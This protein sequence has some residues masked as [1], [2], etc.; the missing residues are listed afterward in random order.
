MSRQ[1][2]SRIL[3][4]GFPRERKNIIFQQKLQS[5]LPVKV[6]ILFASALAVLILAVTLYA[7]IIFTQEIVTHE[8]R[9][10]VMMAGFLSVTP[11]LSSSIF[12]FYFIRRRYP[13]TRVSLTEQV[14]FYIAA[15]V[16]AALACLYFVFMLPGIMD[17]NSVLWRRFSATDFLVNYLAMLMMMLLQLFNS[18][19]GI[20]LI[21]TINR[22]NRI[23]FSDSF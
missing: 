15:V 8:F 14:F 23:E 17:T 7:T 20:A 12:L 3:I 18:I 13:S 5:H 2:R 1:V 4:S 9:I 6:S 10:S 21:R 19:G 16:A 22:K 11:F